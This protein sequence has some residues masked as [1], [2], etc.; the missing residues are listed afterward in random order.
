MPHP[1]S[2]WSRLQA[3]D[4]EA[5]GGS[6]GRARDAL[7]AA[8]HAEDMMHTSIGWV[9]TD[10]LLLAH[11]IG[12]DYTGLCADALV[13]ANE[14]V[15]EGRTPKVGAYVVHWKGKVGEHSMPFGPHERQEALLYAVE[16]K[17]RGYK[18]RVVCLTEEQ[19]ASTEDLDT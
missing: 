3:L 13:E 8:G 7:S 5:Y 1:N 4:N 16:Q 14:G 18:P 17:D 12:R 2:L 9:I 10:L 11:A 6:I 15:I 19:I